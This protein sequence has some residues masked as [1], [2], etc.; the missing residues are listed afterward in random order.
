MY[1]NNYVSYAACTYYLVL[2]YELNLPLET[3]KDNKC[4]KNSLMNPHAP[5]SVRSF[6]K[7]DKTASVLMTASTTSDTDMVFF[8]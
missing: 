2:S 6:D 8:V 7:D 1:R 4:R 3:F 5:I